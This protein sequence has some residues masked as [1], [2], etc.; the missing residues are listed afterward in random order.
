M[1]NALRHMIEEDIGF[2]DITTNALIA[3][4][5]NAR[6]E[7]ISRVEGIVAGI[8]VAEAIFNEFGLNYSTFKSDGDL[9]NS[10]DVLMLIEGNARVLLSVE[11][12]LLNLMMRMSGIATLTAK[13]VKKAKEVNK[14]IIIAGTRKTTPGLQFFE[15]SAIKFGGGD[16]HRFRLDDCVMIKDNHRTMVGD[17]A[18]AIKIVRKNVSFTKKIEVEV[19]NMEDAI[20]ASKVGADII[21]LD[22]MKPHEIE[23]ILKELNNLDLRENVI[24]EAS[25]GI[26]PDNI[27]QYA[28]TGLDVI[29]MGFITHSAP[30]IDLSLEI[31][32]ND[33]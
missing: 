33:S 4:E 25:G 10:G 1:K 18:Q 16:T 32:F 12:T 28:S 6:A 15:K 14:N 21:M 29:S 20:I 30:A 26:N 27:S 19:E 31:T 9:I 24:I 11:R 7:I 8:D 22:N 3:P 17:I 5:V 23:S 13:M 2:E